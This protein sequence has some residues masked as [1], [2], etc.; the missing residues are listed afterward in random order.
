MIFKN[1][2]A[3]LASLALAGCASVTR[4]VHE[5]M[6][7]DSEPSGAEV[8]T[9]IISPCGDKPCQTGNN[10]LPGSENYSSEPLPPQ[11]GPACVT[12]CTAQVRRNERL[13]A[14]FSKPGYKSQTID[15]ET[16]VAGAGAVGFAGNVLI[17]GGVGMAVDAVSGATLE[18]FP[19]P[20]KV[21]LEPIAPPPSPTSPVRKRS[22]RPS[23]PVS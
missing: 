6:Q 7:F 9:E 2:I 11:M 15:I 13:R 20:A 5:Q 22:K 21:I 12:P 23:Q 8:R 3:L 18:H 16:R 4:G 10:A 17:G 1:G 14:T 19:N